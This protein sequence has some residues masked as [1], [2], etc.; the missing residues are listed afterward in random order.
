MCGVSKH[1]TIFPSPLSMLLLGMSLIHVVYL[2]PLVS[3]P[4]G[5]TVSNSFALLKK[6]ELELREIVRGKLS[7][8]VQDQDR[9]AMER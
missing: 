8:A 6:A 3:V 4:L 9:P 5:E 7:Q 1:C 2:L